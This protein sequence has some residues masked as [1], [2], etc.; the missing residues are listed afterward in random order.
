MPFRE[1]ALRG[2]FLFRERTFR[3]KAGKRICAGPGKGGKMR[4]RPPAV[5]RAAGNAEEKET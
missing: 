2:L 5:R 4:P 1:K 3:K